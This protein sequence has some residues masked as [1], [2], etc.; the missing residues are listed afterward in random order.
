MLVIYLFTYTFAYII[1]GIKQKKGLSHCK[2]LFHLIIKSLSD[3]V[4]A[5][6]QAL[7]EIHVFGERVSIDMDEKAL[8]KLRGISVGLHALLPH[9]EKFHYSCLLVIKKPHTAHLEYL[10][11][12]LSQLTAKKYEILV[13]LYD[14]HNPVIEDLIKK[15]NPKISFYSL[16]A[17]T[18]EAALNDLAKK[19]IGNT[20]LLVEEDAWVRPDLLLRYEQ[21]LLLQTEDAILYNDEQRILKNGRLEKIS[22]TIPPFE[23][24]FP[25]FFTIYWPSTLLIPKRLWDQANGLREECKK[26]SFYDLLLRLNLLN[27]KAIRVPIALTARRSY[28]H[29]DAE[30]QHLAKEALQHYADKK[31]L[32]WEI[33]EGYTL[34]TLRALPLIKDEPKIHVIIPFKDQRDLTI[35]AILSLKKQINVTL[36]ITAV[37]N[38][39]HDRSIADELQ[40]LGVEVLYVD[41]PFNFSRL[42]NLAVE[43]SLI[44]KSCDLLFF[45]NNDVELDPEALFEMCR[46]IDQ[47]SIGMVGCR[48]HYPNGLLQ[49]GGIDRDYS[50]SSIQ[51]HWK[52]S[53]AKKAF[54]QLQFQN[55]LRIPDAIHGAALLMKK[56]LFLQVGGFDE[57]W[58]PISFSDTNLA[59]KIQNLN[60][61]A[62][63]TPY[64]TGIHHESIT[65]G[66]NKFEEYES[67]SWLN[68]KHFSKVI[69]R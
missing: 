21:T 33:K 3:Y 6:K 10:L 18:K 20:L 47:P 26:A 42:N 64:A 52:H 40:S 23:I 63:Y 22:T 16:D 62:F 48:L 5:L 31:Q 69:E 43:R 34:D 37:D 50:Q 12:S 27:A 19:A 13:G 38:R 35:K 44:G 65:R 56:E 14:D 59:L 66:H 7:P 45:M 15:L 2:Y 17:K 25:Y 67:S 68:D 46:W 60:L 8:Q 51:V 41:E 61:L 30:T 53:E 9:Q 49:C 28:P 39:S 4:N 1:L 54:H 29:I 11:N 24:H 36:A 55:K 57:I 32:E 58:Y